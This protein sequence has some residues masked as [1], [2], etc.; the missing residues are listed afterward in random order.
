MSPRRFLL[1]SLSAI[2]I[3]R[4]LTGQPESPVTSAAGYQQYL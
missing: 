4:S 3:D 1:E 2:S